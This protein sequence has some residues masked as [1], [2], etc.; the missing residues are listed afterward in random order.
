LSKARR[1]HLRKKVRRFSGRNQVSASNYDVEANV[2]CMV[3]SF[4]N[5]D[6]AADAKYQ[7]DRKQTRCYTMLNPVLNPYCAVYT[8]TRFSMMLLVNNGSRNLCSCII[9]III[10]IIHFLG[11]SMS[12]RPMY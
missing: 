5:L 1:P 9:I 6:I 3:E 7:A 8:M 2:G 11:A 4:L 10:I 12:C